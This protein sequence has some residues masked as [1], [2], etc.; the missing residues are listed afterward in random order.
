MRIFALVELAALFTLW[1]LVVWSSQIFR[2]A[3]YHAVAAALTMIFIVLSSLAIRGPGWFASGFRFDNFWSSLLPVGIATACVFAVIALT[4]LLSHLDAIPGLPV[5]SF[6]SISRPSATGRQITNYVLRGF[7]QE[8]FFLGYLF[9]RWQ[10]LLGHPVKAVAANALSF[11]LIHLPNSLF[12]VLTA[13]GGILFGALF[14]RYR[15]VF[16]MGLAHSVLALCILSVF[17]GSG[18]LDSM[19]IGPAQL[20]PISKTIAGLIEEEDRVGLGSHSLVPAQFGDVLGHKIEKIG[21]KWD[22]ENDRLNTEHL[23]R[24]FED[25]RRVFCVLTEDDFKRYVSPELRDRLHIL[26]AQFAWK[27]KISPWSVFRQNPMT[28]IRN[29]VLLVSNER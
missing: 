20:T 3:S 9:H 27:R 13:I 19:R 26:I 15:N 8:A 11:S 25:E 4:V 23:K 14:V 21:G 6:H 28:A 24:F 10:M 12:V 16:V 17:R 29:R 2:G 1:F 18:V 7:A 5:L 22:V